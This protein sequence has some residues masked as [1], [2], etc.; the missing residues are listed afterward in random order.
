[1]KERK[2]LKDYISNIPRGIKRAIAAGT[3]LSMISF[4]PLP[5]IR[6]DEVYSKQ[7]EDGWKV[8]LS[9]DAVPFI[10]Q[11]QGLEEEMGKSGEIYDEWSRSYE[12]E[13]REEPPGWDDHWNEMDK[14]GSQLNSIIGDPGAQAKT[15]IKPKAS[16][17]TPSG[18]GFHLGGWWLRGSD[19]K[20]GDAPGV[21]Y[22]YEFSEDESGNLYTYKEEGKLSTG[23]VSMWDEIFGSFWGEYKETWT[24]DPNYWWE[25]W[26]FEEKYYPEKAKTKYE[27]SRDFKIMDANL[28]MSIPIVPS[29]S[30]L[31]GLRGQLFEINDMQ[32]VQPIYHS[33]ENYTYNDEYGTNI[34]K[35]I[36]NNNMDLKVNSSAKSLGIGPMVGLSAMK[37]I[38][39]WLRAYGEISKSWIRMKTE[40]TANFLDIDDITENGIFSY[41]DSEGNLIYEDTSEG[42]AYWEGKFPF[43]D[44]RTYNVPLTEINLGLDFLLGKNVTLSAGY[45]KQM[46]QNVPKPAKFHYKRIEIEDEE[47]NDY[48]KLW[49]Y[50]VE[51]KDISAEGFK[52]DVGVRF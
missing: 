2:T 39:K 40:R 11:T 52:V 25:D 45:W 50:E 24:Y 37:N 14:Y 27:I 21:S 23:L 26:T 13:E 12:W 49:E 5:A 48:N 28:F 51:A 41:Y 15:L 8:E 3:L 30:A 43:S 35:Y 36:W 31:A 7:N 29:L 18:V 10:L 17:Y 47:I 38:T 20:K 33:E 32:R 46:M 42:K 34:S 1:M 9:V 19:S 44:T 4:A 6:A 22:S 16:L